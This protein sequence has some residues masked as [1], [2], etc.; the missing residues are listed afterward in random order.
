M[1]AKK[2][3]D[4]TKEKKSRPKRRRR[5]ELPTVQFP[6][7][8]ILTQSPPAELGVP[9]TTKVNIIRKGMVCQS[10]NVRL[11]P[12]LTASKSITKAH[13]PSSQRKLGNKLTLKSKHP[14]QT[15]QYLSDD[16]VETRSESSGGSKIPEIF[17]IPSAESQLMN[18]HKLPKTTTIPTA[19]TFTTASFSDGTVEQMCLMD[20]VDRHQ[21]NSKTDLP[22]DTASVATFRLNP[23][24]SISPVS[25]TD[26]T[27]ENQSEDN[28]QLINSDQVQ[29]Q[30]HDGQLFT[31]FQS[32]QSNKIGS[33]SETVKLQ[34]KNIFYLYE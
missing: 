16:S 31:S 15:I 6:T 17:F 8:Y 1:Y 14:P 9:S 19:V 22:N 27:A 12:E 30:Y 3:K 23:D 18:K 25:P 10:P 20:G 34:D 29:Y 33:K 13:F 28:M 21:S 11:R 32:D 26:C 2:R 5:Q 7:E 4:P 24:G